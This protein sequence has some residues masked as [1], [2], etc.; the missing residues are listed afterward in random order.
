VRQ[1]RGRFS[2]P[3]DSVLP[4]LLLSAGSP[5]IRG[6]TTARGPARGQLGGRRISR[7]EGGRP[8]SCERERRLPDRGRRSGGDRDH[9]SAP[10]EI[11]RSRRSAGRGI[12][13][14]SGARRS[15][16]GCRRSSQTPRRCAPVRKDVIRAFAEAPARR[17][18]THDG[19]RKPDDSA[20]QAWPPAVRS[21]AGPLLAR[22]RV[23]DT[24]LQSGTTAI[25]RRATSAGEGTSPSSRGHH[26]DRR[27][28][29][30]AGGRLDDV[31]R[32]R[33]T[34]PTSAWP[35][36]A[37]AVA[38]TSRR[39]PAARSCRSTACEACPV[40]E[41]ELTRSTA[42]EDGPGDLLG[43]PLEAQYAYSRCPRF[44]GPRVHL[45][46]TALNVRVSRCA[47]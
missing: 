40:I 46:S 37:L 17:R 47:G 10:A 24:V 32:S 7:R 19:R 18:T 21:S 26:A 36:S 30:Q 2:K 1:L 22:V 43:P 12:A 11:A 15:A 38:R 13:R 39:A 4:A 25:D 9:L 45:R 31:V 6:G 42:R 20:C 35:T 34:S 41:I 5:F 14:V 33:R 27:V 3:F 28:S 23:G 16:R 44:R 29:M 8:S